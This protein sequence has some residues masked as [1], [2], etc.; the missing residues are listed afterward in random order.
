LGGGELFLQGQVPRDADLSLRREKSFIHPNGGKKTPENSGL[1]G[2][3]LPCLWE[4]KGFLWKK[5]G[6]GHPALMR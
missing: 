6:T 1:R 4:L 3:T 5:K 2:E